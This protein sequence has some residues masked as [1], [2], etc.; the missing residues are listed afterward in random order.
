MLIRVTGA[1]GERERE[2]ALFS[3]A[4]EM[5][6]HQS[7]ILEALKRSRKLEEDDDEEEE[8]EA[9]QGVH[10]SLIILSDTQYHLSSPYSDLPNRIFLTL[11]YNAATGNISGCIIP[12]HFK[13][14]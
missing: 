9:T 8:V 2:R 1:E 6:L 11:L 5:Q 3:K 12:A 13:V 7:P 10:L 14:K 4:L